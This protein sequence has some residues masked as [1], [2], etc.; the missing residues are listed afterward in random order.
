MLEERLT[1]VGSNEFVNSG[2]GIRACHHLAPC[3]G[4]SVADPD[5]EIP[6]GL[7]AGEADPEPALEAYRCVLA[8]QVSEPGVEGEDA[9]LGIPADLPTTDSMTAA[10]DCFRDRLSPWP[11]HRGQKHVALAATT[12]QLFVGDLPHPF[13][14]SPDVVELR[15]V[16]EDATAYGVAERLAGDFVEPDE[17]AGRM[18]V[19]P[20]LSIQAKPPF[21]THHCH[22]LVEAVAQEFMSECRATPCVI[23]RRVLLTEARPE[24]LQ[25]RVC[26][27]KPHRTV[28]TLTAMM[29]DDTRPIP[30]TSG[31]DLAAAVTAGHSMPLRRS[32]RKRHPGCEVRPLQSLGGPLTSVHGVRDLNQSLDRDA[33]TPVSAG[34]IPQSLL[35]HPVA[36]GVMTTRVSQRPISEVQALT[37]VQ[38]EFSGGIHRSSFQPPAGIR[39]STRVP[40]RRSGRRHVHQIV[41]GSGGRLTAAGQD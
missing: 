18:A 35:R 36:T 22:F 2:F 13:L 23:P 38:R 30:A 34:V 16:A 6:G 11:L 4:L 41:G 28:G 3:I 39:V 29:V 25:D 37:A 33:G 24:V 32:Q 19:Q 8:F 21:C 27:G 26:D 10:E 15:L 7:L 14:G 31:V 9:A 20:S 17:E 5:G 1:V 40:S 12:V